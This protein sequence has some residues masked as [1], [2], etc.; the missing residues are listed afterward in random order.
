MGMHV[1]VVSY[2]LCEHFGSRVVLRAA[3]TISYRVLVSSIRSKSWI[4]ISIFKVEMTLEAWGWKRCV[5]NVVQRRMFLKTV[6]RASESV[7]CK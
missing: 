3:N 7:A 2:T 4:L 5:S 6:S 1:C